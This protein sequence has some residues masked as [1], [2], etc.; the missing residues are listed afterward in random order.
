[1]RGSIIFHHGWAMGPWYWT[2]LYPLL[3]HESFILPSGKRLAIGHSLGFV[4]LLLMKKPFDAYIGLQGF[5]NFLGNDQALQKKRGR[6]LQAMIT[7]FQQSPEK[8]LK[9]FHLSCGISPQ[10]DYPVDPT[11]LFEDLRNLS[12]NYTPL[13][14]Q[15]K[16]LIIGSEEDPVVPL[17]LLKDN[18]SNHSTVHLDILPGKHHA[19]GFL[20][21]D[22][23]AQR[24]KKFIENAF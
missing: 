20:E 12:E 2:N 15:K 3:T 14:S 7:A 9:S 24:I 21:A 8:T 5:V 4:K 19:L 22:V 17:N 16:I 10:E 13:L 18:F 1:M 6:L 11:I 23:I